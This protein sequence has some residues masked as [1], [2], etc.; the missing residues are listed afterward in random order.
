MT[1]SAGNA[2]SAALIQLD[3]MI[4]NSQMYAS[5]CGWGFARFKTLKMIP[6]GKM[7]LLA[8]ECISCRRLMKNQDYVFTVPVK[9]ERHEGRKI[10]SFSC[11]CSVYMW[12]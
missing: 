4:K 8:S 3:F 2:R 1:D 12:L 9:A 7:S 10:F 6:Y 5:T 11:C